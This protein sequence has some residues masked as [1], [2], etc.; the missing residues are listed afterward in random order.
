[1][2]GIISMILYLIIKVTKIDI[3]NRLDVISVILLLD[4]VS[5]ISFVNVEESIVVSIVQA[6]HSPNIQSASLI[7]VR[8]VTKKII[9]TLDS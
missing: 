2:T 7:N 8:N 5:L 4:L 1:M 3:H 6:K 9:S